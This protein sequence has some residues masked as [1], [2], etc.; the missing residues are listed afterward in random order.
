M[1]TTL[2]RG[3][4]G[5]SS[6]ASSSGTRTPVGVTAWYSG[7]PC[8]SASTSV[9]PSSSTTPNVGSSPVVYLAMRTTRGYRP[10]LA[11]PLRGDRSPL[12]CL[13][14]GFGCSGSLPV[15]CGA[16]GRVA[17]GRA[18]PR[19]PGRRVDGGTPGPRGAGRAAPGGR[20][21]V[22]LLPAPAGAAA[23]LA[24][25]GRCGAG[26]RLCAGAPGLALV[27]RGRGRGRGGPR[28]VPRGACLVR[29]VGPGPPGRDGWSSRP[30]G[31]L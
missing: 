25:G 7:S 8:T 28:R 14:T 1:P 10:A 20:L 5:A 16:G 9:P 18:P 26:R 19:G 11:V 24:P 13:G 17:G 12:S 21:P 22:D 30:A 27:P 3:M 23:P 31:L 15:T 6:R 4:T 29:A 2:L